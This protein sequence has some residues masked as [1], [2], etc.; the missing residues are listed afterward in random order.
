MCNNFDT[1]QYLIKKCLAKM[2][3]GYYKIG[4]TLVELSIVIVIIGLIIG[5]VLFGR[6]LIKAAEIRA[7][8]TQFSEFDIAIKTFRLKY[9]DYL[10]G[11]IPDAV[12]TAYGICCGSGGTSNGNGIIEGYNGV[13]SNVYPTY[14]L[15]AEPMV[16]FQH[17]SLTGL[18]KGRYFSC[19]G[20]YSYED[21]MQFPRAKIANAGI[22]AYSKAD[23]KL[24][25][26]LGLNR[27]VTDNSTNL[28]SALSTAG[29]IS[30]TDAYALDIKTDDG[31]PTTGKI[32]SATIT[33]IRPAYDTSDGNCST[34]SSNTYNVQNTN[35]YCRLIVDVQ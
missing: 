8:V 2:L 17:L 21:G 19:F 12:K 14:N 34:A 26:F 30:P 11:D 27:S 28:V 29:V 5:G 23:T 32:R 15:Y 33:A 20:C 1:K 3:S 7:Q 24:A 9:A 31:L 16:F 35:I 18:I 25:Y 22:F 13:S 4:F 10:P 6:D